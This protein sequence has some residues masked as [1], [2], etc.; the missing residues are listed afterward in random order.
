MH[1]FLKIRPG[2][3]PKPSIS[4]EQEATELWKLAPFSERIHQEVISHEEFWSA[5]DALLAQ[6][7]RTHTLATIQQSTQIINN[8]PS[9]SK[10]VTFRSRKPS[11]NV[12]GLLT[13]L[14]VAILVA[15]SS[16]ATFM[17]CS[18]V[19]ILHVILLLFS[20]PATKLVILNQEAIIIKNQWNHQKQL[21]L[22]PDIQSVSFYSREEDSDKLYIET[23]EMEFCVDVNIKHRKIQQLFHLL[24]KK[25]ITINTT[26]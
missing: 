1:N 2:S 13:D 8:T 10:K 26:L 9:A 12:V 11:L 21:F 25:G 4:S 14:V 19:V 23:L 5:Y 17:F 15:P 6:T 7:R 24:Q 18:V 20:L 22:Y 3:P 16:E